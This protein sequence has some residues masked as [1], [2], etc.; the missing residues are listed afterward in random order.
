MNHQFKILFGRGTKTKTIRDLRNNG[1]TVSE[2][3]DGAYTSGDALSE[4]VRAFIDKRILRGI[5][6]FP[7][8]KTRGN[9]SQSDSGANKLRDRYEKEL[10]PYATPYVKK[11]FRQASSSW[12][13]GDTHIKITIGNVP[14]AHGEAKRVR[15][16]NG[17][18]SGNNA[19][20]HITVSGNWRRDTLS[21]DGLVDAGGML[22]THAKRLRDGTWQA[23][24]VRQGKGFDLI[25]ESGV[26]LLCQIDGS[27]EW[28]HAKNE[29]AAWRVYN[30][31]VAA[32][33]LERESARYRRMSV[34]ELVAEFPN[35]VVEIEDSYN[36]GNCETGTKN[37]IASKFGDNRTSATAAEI[38]A[39]D[40]NNANV[41]RAIR[42]AMDK[43]RK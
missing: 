16:A 40:P 14:S 1:F 33:A 17:K 24:W 36:A 22:T 27:D 18:W 10:A 25:A 31:R 29:K 3:E 37:W 42:Q 9:K 43:R 23:S 41:T 34:A 5:G 39:L 20:L 6:N 35:T 11:L 7:T 21:V 13:G 4:K 28:I 15:S 19:Y 32:I 30:N 8:P 38:Y 2:R 26:I 12:A